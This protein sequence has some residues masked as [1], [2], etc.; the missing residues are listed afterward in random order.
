VIFLRNHEILVVYYSSAES[1]KNIL[2]LI[3]VALADILGE[4]ENDITSQFT[5]V[6]IYFD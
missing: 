6:K 3:P 4:P 2:K 5:N 1:A